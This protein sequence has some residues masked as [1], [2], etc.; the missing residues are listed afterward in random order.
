M[1]QMTLEDLEAQQK[2]QNKYVR[3]EHYDTENPK[4]VI[5]IEIVVKKED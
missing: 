1:I 5:P 3:R 4:I 2:E